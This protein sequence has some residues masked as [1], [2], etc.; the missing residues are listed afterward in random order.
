MWTYLNDILIP[1][2]E[3]KVSV[4][5]RGF[6]YGDG[7]FETLAAYNSTI[8]RLEAHLDRFFASANYLGIDVPVDRTTLMQRL[9]TCLAKNEKR[10]AILR[11]S[12]SR[13]RSN[14]GLGTEACIEP[15][16]V[17]LCFPP[18]LYPPRLFLEGVKVTLSSVC[19]MPLAAS[20]PQAKTTNFLNN[21]LAFREAE[22]KGAAEAFMLNVNGDL[23]EGSVSNLFLVL[24]GELWTPSLECGVVPGITRA[25]VMQVAEQ[26]KIKVHEARLSVEALWAASEAFYT[27][28]VVRIM[29]IAMIDDHLL[30]APGPVTWSL[31]SALLDL[32]EREAGPFWTVEEA[33]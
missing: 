9:Y 32:I 16:L 8:F 25:A 17:I 31:R 22:V 4:L 12:L 23:A 2:E 26:R 29:P 30:G 28:T 15:T 6:L 24:E 18:K 10:N 14:R 1:I 21:I 11:M 27:N 13:G 33:V 20:S 5:D 3:A 19:R 7:L